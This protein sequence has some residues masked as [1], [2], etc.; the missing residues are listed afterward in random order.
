MKTD[1]N[2]A[3]AR[4]ATLKKTQADTESRT[5]E[6]RADNNRVVTLQHQI[7][8]QLGAL[9]TKYRD[10]VAHIDTLEGQLSTLATQKDSL[11]LPGEGA[12]SDVAL[13]DFLSEWNAGLSITPPCQEH[14]HPATSS[15]SSC[16]LGLW[17]FQGLKRKVC[18]VEGLKDRGGGRGKDYIVLPENINLDALSAFEFRLLQLE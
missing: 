3:L 12:D 8:E 11:A 14:H 10:A 13:D 16:G 4:I 2:A 6:L 17:Q 1:Y 18:L 7:E 15:S 9:Q 5:Q